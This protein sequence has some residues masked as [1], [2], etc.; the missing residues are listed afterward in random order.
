MEPDD[1]K[2]EK[3][4]N[5]WIFMMAWLFVSFA[6]FIQEKGF[7]KLAIVDLNP[8]DW[9]DSGSLELFEIIRWHDEGGPDFAPD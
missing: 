5:S 4:T 6:S 9:Q 1:D 2:M 7:P 8:G 3:H